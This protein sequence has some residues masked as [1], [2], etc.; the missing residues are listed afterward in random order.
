MQVQKEVRQ[1]HHNAIAAILRHG[2]AKD[3]L[4]YLRL[5]DHFTNGHRLLPRLPNET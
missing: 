3:A 4:P 1:H 5:A 2:V